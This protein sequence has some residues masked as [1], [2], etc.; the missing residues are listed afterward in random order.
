MGEGHHL[1]TELEFAEL[2]FQRQPGPGQT[3]FEQF[4][5]VLH[6]L[7]PGAD[8][9]DEA[10]AAGCP[11][12]DLEMDPTGLNTAASAAASIQRA[13]SRTLPSIREPDWVKSSWTSDD[14]IHGEGLIDIAVQSGH[15]PDHA[16]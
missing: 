8:Q 7:E 1:I 4:G 5:T 3:P 9:G 11:S 15:R 14:V 13:P 2:R 10:G 12:A 6:G 16:P